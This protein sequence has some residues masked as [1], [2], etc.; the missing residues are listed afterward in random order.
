MI[1]R[2]IWSDEARADIRAIDRETALR[3]LKALARFLQTES[4]N[5]KQLQGFEPPRY[6]LRVG[7]W[8]FIFRSLGKVPSKSFTSKIA[9]KPIDKPYSCCGAMLDVCS[10]ISRR[11]LKPS[12]QLLSCG[13]R[14]AQ[15]LCGVATTRLVQLF[16]QPGSEPRQ[17]GSTLRREFPLDSKQGSRRSL[18]TPFPFA[19]QTSQRSSTVV[20][21]AGPSDRL[22][23]ALTSFNQ[24]I[25]RARS[26]FN[27]PKPWHVD[28]IKFAVASR[29]NTVKFLETHEAVGRALRKLN[30]YYLEVS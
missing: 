15:M 2:V 3:L 19:C 26:L 10:D 16:H 18:A 25:S 24:R 27:Q 13:L 8:R 1:K 7:D 17:S 30:A 11:F 4:G 6:R 21:A 9:E 12:H 22:R 5:V 23:L 20:P 28:L 29:A 14:T